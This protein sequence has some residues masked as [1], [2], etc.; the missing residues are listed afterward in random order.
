MSAK[1]FKFVS[2]GVFL[3]EIDNSILP[4]EPREIGPMIIGRAFRGPANRPVTVDS[5]EEFVNIYGNPV[6]GGNGDDVW[7]NGNKITPMYGSYAAQAWLKNSPTL[8]YFRL[9][10]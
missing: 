9:G 5:F 4:R 10:G 8:T 6:A 2:P 1:K 7:R 3:N